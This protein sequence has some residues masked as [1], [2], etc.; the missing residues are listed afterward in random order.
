MD[1]DLQKDILKDFLD[2]YYPGDS[3]EEWFSKI[4]SIAT[5]RGL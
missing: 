2:T 3:V 1:K 5:K 4:K